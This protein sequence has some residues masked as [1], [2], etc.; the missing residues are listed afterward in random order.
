MAAWD[1][2]IVGGG[3]A[4]STLA[5]RLSARGS[6]RVLLLE[7][8]IDT[9]HENVPEIVHD[10]Y[11][12]TV[13][14]HPDFI[15]NGLKVSLQPVSHNRPDQPPPL[16]QYEQARVMG[17]GSSI[18]GQ[19]ANR[20]APTDY[21]EWGE[22]GAEGWNWETCL[23]YFRKLERD[24]DFEDGFHGREGPIGIRRIFADSWPGISKA[25]SAAFKEKG[26]P[27]L[28][29]QNGAFADGHFAI[30][31]SNVNDRRLSAALG[32]LDPATRRRENLTIESRIQVREILFD[33]TRATGVIA[34][35]GNQEQ[36]F[37]AKE[38]ILCCGSLHSPA[39]LMR[40]GIGPVGH[41]HEMNI[42][43]RL[44][45]AGVGQNL[46]EHPATAISAWMRPEVRLNGMTRRHLHVGMRY[47]SNMHDAPPG[48]M[49][50]IVVAKS[51]WHGIGDRLGAMLMWINKSYST[52]EVRLS[53]SDW[54]AE[55]DVAF[56]MLSDRRDLDR[57]MDAF[58]R[59]AA[60]FACGAVASVTSRPFPSAYSEKVRKVGTVTTRNKIITSALAA[61]LDGPRWLRDFLT[62]TVITEGAGLDIL[63]SDDAAL[64]E[65]LRRNVHGIW[66]ASCTNRMGRED[67]PMAVTDN[68]G[69]VHGA[70]GLRVVDASIMP[71]VPCANT[72]IPTIMTAEKIADMMLA[73]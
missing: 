5:N 62:E 12:G 4:G 68:Q 15:W 71:V 37:E 43:I 32:Y 58:R 53:S 54:R 25:F 38:V 47:S 29:D 44:E 18:N 28:P 33:G 41:L 14:F 19:L 39:M 36:T 31:I 16:R 48:D 2:I 22:R 56:N 57:L 67:D 72:N 3:S 30:A 63:L 20:G 49:F 64:E 61:M 21:D 59:T 27:Y 46:M 51:A 24:L 10:S 23:P 42:P 1:Y 73:G 40:A 6:N 7:A 34:V 45:R 66:H 65:H 55:P 70:Q 35:R 50:A 11:P 17:G 52:G 60:V 26:Y 8:G 13:Y 69:R 9:P